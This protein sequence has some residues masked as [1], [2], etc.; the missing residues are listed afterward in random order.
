MQLELLTDTPI[1]STAQDELGTASFVRR[2]VEP[3]ISWP[4]DQPLVAGLFGDWGQGKTSALNLLEAELEQGAKRLGR[5]VI[6]VRFNPWHYSNPESLLLS[7]FGTLAAR[8]GASFWSLDFPRWKLQRSLKSLGTILSVATSASGG[9]GAAAVAS[10]SLKAAEILLAKG[11]NEIGTLKKSARRR[12]LELG[13]RSPPVRV[14]FLIDDL[15]RAQP[16]EIRVMLRLVR[17]IADL[18]N[19]SYVIA[20]DAVRVRQLLSIDADGAYGLGYLDKIVQVP[21]QLPPVSPERLEGLVRVAVADVFKNAGLDASFLVEESHFRLL[22]FYPDTLGRRLR[23]LRDRARLVNALRFMLLS[24]THLDVHAMDSLFVSFLQ[25]FYPDVHTRVHQNKLFLTGQLL[26]RE[27]VLARSGGREQELKKRYHDRFRTIITGAQHPD[28]K[29]E[30]K[31][32]LARS[33]MDAADVLTVESVLKQLFPLAEDGFQF[34]GQSALQLRVENRVQHKDRFERYFFLRA[35][36]DEVADALV[37]ATLTELVETAPEANSL[38]VLSSPDTNGKRQSFAEKLEDRIPSMVPPDRALAVAQALVRAP[39]AFNDEGTSSAIQSLAERAMQRSQTRDYAALQRQGT[40]AATPVLLVGVDGL[41]DDVAGFW[42]AVHQVFGR[43]IPLDEAGRA[44][45]AEAGL[46]RMRSYVQK[47][48]RLFHEETL[49]PI[50]VVWRWRDLFEQLKQDSREIRDYL[51]HQFSDDMGSLLAFLAPLTTRTTE[52]VLVFG[53]GSAKPEVLQALESVVGVQGLR[54]LCD[55]YIRIVGADSAADPHGL[56]RLCREYL[57]EA[58]PPA[59]VDAAA[60]PDG[61]A[62]PEVG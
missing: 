1:A 17:L 49:E 41:L 55:K 56:L 60:K 33:G 25:T 8:V 11:E 26:E 31:A 42:F 22:N 47:G 37:N 16:E 62:L 50:R 20:M 35:P 48:S 38:R 53:Y 34:G 29:D 24:G 40:G 10:V 3:L 12:L 44:V 14:V 54:D 6:L 39:R 21:I 5:R 57:G 28:D 27:A 19:T 51:M 18:P 58:V 30:V 43:D 7:F 2:M 36:G 45:L 9:P 13:R 46:R 61:G 4:S 23:T 52:G 32:A 59:E 15:D